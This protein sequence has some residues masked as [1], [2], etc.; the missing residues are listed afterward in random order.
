MYSYK[1]DNARVLMTF[2]GD[3]DGEQIREAYRMVLT[4]PAFASGYQILVDDRATTFDPS[5]EEAQG[6]AEF[7]ASLAGSVPQLAVVVRK[8]VHF[9]IGR[10]VEVLCENRGIRL[11]T[12][13]ALDEAEAWLDTA[14]E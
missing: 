12:L 13:R 1:I 6:L 14:R 3:L 5:M 9:G 8:E 4:D 11:R 10:M 2:E 7:F